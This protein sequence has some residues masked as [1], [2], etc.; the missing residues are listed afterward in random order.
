MK[1]YFEREEKVLVLQ[2]IT[3]SCTRCWKTVRQ[4]TCRNGRRLVVQS[5]VAQQKLQYTCMGALLQAFQKRLYDWTFRGLARTVSS[6]ASYKSAADD[7]HVTGYTQ[8]Y[9]PKQQTPTNYRYVPA[10]C[11]WLVATFVKSI[12]TGSCMP[13][14]R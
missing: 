1:G 13:A 8:H 7:Q 3:M 10:Q 5:V 11:A 2:L 12:C 4:C 9:P 14:K 6:R